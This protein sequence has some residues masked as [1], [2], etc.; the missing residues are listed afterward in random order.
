MPTPVVRMHYDKPLT[1]MSVA[2]IQAQEKFIARRVFPQVTTEFQSDVYYVWD[3]DD[4]MRDEAQLRAPATEAAEVTARP[5]TEPFLCRE[6]ALKE[7]IPWQ[8]RDNADKVL[9]MEQAAMMRISQKLL[10]RQDRL[11]VEKYFKD[12]VWDTTYTGKSIPSSAGEFLAWGETGSTPVQ[13]VDAAKDYIE[14]KTGFRPNVMVVSPSV[15]TLLKHHPDIIDRIKYTERGI[16][17]IDL[18]K[19]LFDLDAF[20]V[21]RGVFTSTPKGAASQSRGFIMTDG[22]LLAY[23]PDAAGIETPSAGY[24]FAWQDIDSGA[25]EYGGGF[26]RY[27]VEEKKCDYV[28]GEFCLDFKVVG[29]DLAAFFKDPIEEGQ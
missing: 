6:Y 29:K 22:V 9:N 24:T 11:W 5:A 19:A 3:K 1:D 23:A 12:S 8:R 4:Y 21:G 28:E 16:V 13:D 2:Y 17:T 25:G 27:G 20:L 18:L 26:R 15:L 14:S 7:P 10:I